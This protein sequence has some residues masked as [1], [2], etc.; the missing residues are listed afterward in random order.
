MNECEAVSRLG[1]TLDDQM[2]MIGHKAMGNFFHLHFDRG[3]KNLGMHA[4][5]NVCGREPWSAPIGAK[6]EEIA[7]EAD[8]AARVEPGTKMQHELTSC[9]QAPNRVGGRAGLQAC[10]P[11]KMYRRPSGLPGWAALKG[12]ATGLRYM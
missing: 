1:T 5:D 6:R 9:K 10:P 7:A 8:I 3:A 12:C 11:R 4:I 2:K